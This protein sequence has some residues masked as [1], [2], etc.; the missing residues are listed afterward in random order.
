MTQSISTEPIKALFT[1]VLDSL[2]RPLTEDVTDDVFYAIE[3]TPDWMRRYSDLCEI[4][5]KKTVNTWGG[6]WVAN[7]VERIGLSQVAAQKSTLILSYSKLDRP[8]PPKSFKKN[9][10]DNARE[11]VF[12]YYKVNS[13]TLPS[14]ARALREEI[15]ALVI[16]GMSPTDAFAVALNLSN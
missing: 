5:T 6:Y 16:S 13:A 3:K 2:P 14:K 9:T 1:E 4:R 15:V 8:A 12:A 11:Q 7:A 10:E